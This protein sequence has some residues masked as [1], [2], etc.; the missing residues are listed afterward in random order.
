MSGSLLLYKKC[1]SRII[2]FILFALNSFQS[3]SQNVDFGKSYINLSKGINGGTVETGDTLEIRAIEVT[4]SRVGDAPMLPELLNQIPADQ[5]I[6][7]VSADGAYDT[8]PAMRR[9][10]GAG[11]QQ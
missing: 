7:K 4:G 5:P 2:F 1:N 3:S 6:D 10:P 11:Q 9:L 8:R